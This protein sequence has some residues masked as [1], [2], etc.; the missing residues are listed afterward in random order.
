MIARY[1]RLYA[2]QDPSRARFASVAVT[3]RVGDSHVSQKLRRASSAPI[4]TASAA[5]VNSLVGDLNACASQDL[6]DAGEADV[7]AARSAEPVYLE[8]DET[9]VRGEHYSALIA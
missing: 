7:A 1:R 3:P 5:P 9:S 8:L 4:R 2:A 6:A